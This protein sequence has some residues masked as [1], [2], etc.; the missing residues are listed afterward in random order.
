MLVGLLW[1]CRGSLG[2]LGNAITSNL[3]LTRPDGYCRLNVS[4]C[5][6]KMSDNAEIVIYLFVQILRI[7]FKAS[8]ATRFFSL[9]GLANN[10]KASRKCSDKFL[11]ESIIGNSICPLM[12]H[13]SW[14]WVN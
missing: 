13:P 1:V 10:N 4:G 14:V 5:L 2:V 7:I 11:R 8:G 9:T 3:D 12:R 6:F